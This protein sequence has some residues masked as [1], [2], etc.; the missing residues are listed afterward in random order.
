M[1]YSDS[2]NSG[3]TSTLVLLALV[4]AAIVPSALVLG[5]IVPSALVLAAIVLYDLY[6]QQ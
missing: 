5:E 4:L 6:S 1:Q 2:T 3:S